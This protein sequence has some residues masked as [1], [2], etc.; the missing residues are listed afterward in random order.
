VPRTR[1]LSQAI[2]EGDGISLI[3]EVDGAADA[4]E[5][6]AAGAKAVVLRVDDTRPVRGATRLPLIVAGDDA[7]GLADAAIVRPGEP[8]SVGATELVFSVATDEELREVL[9]QHDAEILLLSPGDDGLEP[10]LEL[11]ADVPAGKLAIGV[12]REPRAEEL[13][14]LERAGCDAVLVGARAPAA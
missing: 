4:A 8:V 5:A 2:S 9:E 13:A 7:H 11:L 14:E 12:L 3:V 10:V 1:R 6:E